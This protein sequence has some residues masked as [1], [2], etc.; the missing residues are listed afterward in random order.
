M[1]KLDMVGLMV[2]VNFMVIFI[3][4]MVVFCFFGGKID[5]MMVWFSGIEIFILID[6]IIWLVKR[7][8]KFGV[9]KVMIVLIKNVVIVEMYIIWEFS[10]LIN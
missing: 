9:V 8:L 5:N 4:F 2:G 1:I 7:R 3:I 10:L 6:W